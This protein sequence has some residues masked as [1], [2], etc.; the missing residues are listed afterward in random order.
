[1]CFRQIQENQR[2]FP[3]VELSK[4]SFLSVTLNPKLLSNKPIHFSAG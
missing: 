4:N 2:I 1:M 3:V